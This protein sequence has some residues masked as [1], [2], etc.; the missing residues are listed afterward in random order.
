VTRG[1]ELLG[2]LE[3]ERAGPRPVPWAWWRFALVLLLVVAVLSGLA[4]R[5]ANQLASPLEQLADAADRFGAGNLAFRTD[6]GR[7]PLRW[8]VRE[9]RDVAVSFNRMAD[10]VEATVRGQRELLGAIS[11]ELR[12]PLGRAR[13]ALEIARDRLAP[14]PSERSPARAL[15]DVDAQL[16]AV[17]RLLGDLLDVTRAGLADLRRERRAIADWVKGCLVDEPRPPPIEL[18]VDPGAADVEASIDPALLARAVHNLLL[19]ARAHGHPAEAPIEVSI[20][21]DGDRVR[22]VVR[23]RGPGFPEGFADKAFEPFVR[24]DASRARPV[25]GSGHG[26]GLAIVRRVVEAHGGRTFARN[27]PERG[28][29]VGFDLPVA[30]SP[31]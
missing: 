31:R 27:A 18:A 26:L 25:A 5:V 10:R 22:I 2:A 3:L 12:S 9:V 19:N 1:A 8:T 20:A 24:A 11:H 29:E 6:V 14:D 21:R 13:V 7:G 15:D 16:T 4:G 28:A 23:D 30:P 17:D